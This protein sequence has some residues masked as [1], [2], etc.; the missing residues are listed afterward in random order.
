MVEAERAGRWLDE[1]ET[2]PEDSANLQRAVRRAR[3]RVRA[4][5]RATESFS[6]FVTLTLDA[7]KVER[8][9]EREVIRKASAW[10][11]NQVQRRGLAYVLVPERHK[12]GA[13]HFHGFFNKALDFVESG[14]IVPP[15]GGKPRRP[16]SAK[17]RAEWLDSG[18]HDVFNIPAWSF[19]FSTAI[20]LYGPRSAAVGYVCKYIGKQTAAELPEKIGGRWYYSGGELSEPETHYADLD[21]DAARQLNPKGFSFKV[22]EACA[23]YYAFE[24]GGDGRDD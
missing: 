1:G 5:A 24:I 21:L 8:Y 15:E 3:A 13:I 12:D 17:Q 20:G 23:E 18:G 22:P 2:P 11:S 6:Y 4:L 14:T 9:D 7:Q 10:L 19:G 16:R